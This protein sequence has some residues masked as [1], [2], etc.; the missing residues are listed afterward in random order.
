MFPLKKVLKY[1]KMIQLT[2]MMPMVNGIRQLQRIQQLT[3]IDANICVTAVWMQLSRG[4]FWYWY[5][6]CSLFI[7]ATEGYD[8]PKDQ[9]NCKKTLCSHVE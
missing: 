7:T 9:N 3:A 2:D 6:N 4:G 8:D 1:L 5:L